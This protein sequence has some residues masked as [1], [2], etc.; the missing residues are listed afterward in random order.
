MFGDMF[1]V[2]LVPE[3]PYKGE[4]WSDEVIKLA[5]EHETQGLIGEFIF[6][7]ICTNDNL[8]KKLLL[9]TLIHALYKP[10]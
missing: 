6:S 3:V 4:V 10:I 8:I 2:S 5:V 9:L 7:K 1:G